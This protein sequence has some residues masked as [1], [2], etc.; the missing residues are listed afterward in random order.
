[1][2]SVSSRNSISYTATLFNDLMALG[3]AITC[4]CVIAVAAA[5]AAAGAGYRRLLFEQWLPDGSAD[6]VGAACDP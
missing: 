5:V 4:C 2:I 3:C 6:H 1:M